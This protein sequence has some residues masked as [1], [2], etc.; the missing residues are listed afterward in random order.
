MTLRL[1]HQ[2]GHNSKWNIDSFEKD[3]CGDGLILSPL[4]QAM[5]TVENLSAQ[6][7]A[8]SIFD[9][10]FYLPNSRKGKLLS[11]P[12]FPEQVDG[13]F[14]TSTFVAHVSEVAKSCIDFQV[15]QGFRKVVVPTRY[16][17]QMYPTYF[18]Q[19]NQFTVNAFMEHAGTRPLNRPGI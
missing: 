12:F 7:R 16:I 11:Y 10:Q 8:A 9:P 6:T 5:G 1:L 18:T 2:V 15:E 14:Q 19:Q 3:G 4:H 17:N 13:G